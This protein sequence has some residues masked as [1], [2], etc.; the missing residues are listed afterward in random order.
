MEPFKQFIRPLCKLEKSITYLK[1]GCSYRCGNAFRKTMMTPHILIPVCTHIFHSGTPICAKQ[2]V[3]DACI[4]IP[5]ENPDDQGGITCM[6][7]RIS[8]FIT[9]GILHSFGIHVHLKSML[10]PYVYNPS[11]IE[12]Q[13]KKASIWG[14]MIINQFSYLM[15][16][17][18]KMYTVDPYIPNASI[19]AACTSFPFIIKD[20]YYLEL[21][22]HIGSV[23]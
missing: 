15:M 23:L 22:C 9:I 19:W 7:S 16:C 1:F 10:I 4:K 13:K 21:Y 8:L 14:V 20:F 5:S 2:G 12:I 18:L 17:N 6:H 11:D 3:P